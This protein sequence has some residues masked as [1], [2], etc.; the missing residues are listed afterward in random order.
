MGYRVKEIDLHGLYADEVE[1]A[2]ANVF[3]E[4]TAYGISELNIIYGKGDGVLKQKVHSALAN[5]QKRIISTKSYEANIKISL[6]FQES[7]AKIYKKKLAEKI[8]EKN[9][10]AYLEEVQLKKQKGREKY[11]K[12]MKLK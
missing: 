3:T 9:N 7:K 4:C 10:K 1:Y 2:L 5:Y 12:R 6:K 11:S 8:K